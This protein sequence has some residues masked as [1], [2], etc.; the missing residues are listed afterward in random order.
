MWERVI[1]FLR[2]LPTPLV[3]AVVF[4]VT[5][6]EGGALAGLIAP[7]E[8]A[9]LVAGYMV[10]LGKLDLTTLL[11]GATAA[12]IAG[13]SLGFL[14]GRRYGTT[15]TQSRLGRRIGEQNW[16][17]AHAFMDKHGERAVFVGKFVGFMRALL[18]FS[19]GVG[20]MP[21]GK[22]LRSN[23]PACVVFVVGSVLLGK[24]A[25]AAAEQYLK[26]F[27]YVVLGLI[28]LWVGFHVA[29]KR[30]RQSAQSAVDR[31]DS[32]TSTEAPEV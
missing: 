9:L 1:D 16:N 26:R 13:D 10:A 28:A 29:K 27:G 22:F 32:A 14:L 18:P 19:A 12:S 7:G 31:T 23:A 8:V 17:R 6:A 5:I 2:S 15:V 25:G 3:F 30:R 11:I 20:T 4:S 24:I 21:Y